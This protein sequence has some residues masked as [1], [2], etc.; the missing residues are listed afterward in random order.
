M[1]RASPQILRDQLGLGNSPSGRISIDGEVCFGLKYL[2]STMLDASMS[3]RSS[4]ALARMPLRMRIG[5][6]RTGGPLGRAEGARFRREA[7]RGD[8][9]SATLRRPER[10]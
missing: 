6:P 8:D 2:Y 4:A 10:T 1:L 7:R 5:D 9:H 3:I